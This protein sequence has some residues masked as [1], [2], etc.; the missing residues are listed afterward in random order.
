MPGLTS[1][2]RHRR[3]EEPTTRHSRHSY[4]GCTRTC[5][6]PRGAAWRRV[7]PGVA[8]EKGCQSHAR[9]AMRI[10]KRRVAARAGCTPL[11]PPALPSGRAG[12]SRSALCVRMTPKMRTRP[13]A[14]PLRTWPGRRHRRLSP[15]APAPRG[16]WPVSSAPSWPASLADHF[17]DDHALPSQQGRDYKSIQL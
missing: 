12:W 5:M 11:R 17:Q 3:S 15:S 13:T 4:A 6:P 8:I 10:C 7:P 16:L 14:P 1:S 2:T 9:A